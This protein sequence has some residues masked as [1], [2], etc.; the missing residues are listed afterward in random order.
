MHEKRINLVVE[1]RLQEEALKK[2]LGSILP[3]YHIPRVFCK[4]GRGYI[5]KKLESFNQASSITP[6]LVLTDLDRNPCAPDLI[7]KWVTDFAL[8]PNLIFR[9]AVREVET[10]L[11]ADRKNFANFLGVSKDKILREIESEKFPKQLIVR[12]AKKSKKRLIREKIVPRCKY[13]KV[14]PEYNSALVEFILTKWDYKVA[15]EASNSL[16]KLILSLRRFEQ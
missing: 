13:V 15:A 14:G 8:H 12:L 1:D 16:S 9:V 2:I 3:K 10:W 6:Y 11:L 4:N 7:K 5:K